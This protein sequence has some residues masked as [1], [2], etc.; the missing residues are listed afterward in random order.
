MA[1]SSYDDAHD[2]LLEM[3]LLS[4]T[5]RAVLVDTAVYT[6]AAGHTMAD[7]PSAARL[8]TSPA[9]SGGAVSEGSY[10]VAGY[11]FTAPDAAASVALVYYVDYGS[12]AANRL[13]SYIPVTPSSAPDGVRDIQVNGHAPLAV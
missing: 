11:T 10:T 3:A 9:M 13:L 12:D 6:Y 1:A 8:G 7:I 5:V 2:Y 4:S